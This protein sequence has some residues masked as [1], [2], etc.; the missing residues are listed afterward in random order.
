MY[1][2]HELEA[3]DAAQQVAARL[4]RAFQ[5]AT[6][7]GFLDLITHPW[8]QRCGAEAAIELG[9]LP[10]DTARRLVRALQREEA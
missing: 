3:P 2:E 10:L 4:R 6:G 7:G 8:C 1:G 9:D 5:E